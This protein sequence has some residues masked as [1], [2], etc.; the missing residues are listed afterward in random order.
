[1]SKTKIPVLFERRGA[2]GICPST[3][4]WRA[5]IALAMKGVE[6]Q[7]RP[8][9]FV[10]AD[11]FAAEVG[12]RQVPVLVDGGKTIVGSDRI[13]MHLDQTRVGPAVGPVDDSGPGTKVLESDLGSRILPL[14]ARDMLPHLAPEDRDYYRA[15]R[16]ERLGISFE[17]LEGKRTAGELDLA[18]AIGRLEGSL[19]ELPFFA[20]EAPGWSDVVAFC[21]LFWI[22]HVSPRSVP[23]L[24][25]TLRAWYEGR[26]DAWRS[27][28]L[29]PAE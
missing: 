3:V 5:R 4:C 23:E 24:P 2:N 1:M 14:V 26:R 11:D 9:R 25:Y 29:E 16:E 12:T 6:H 19:G 8:M 7:R 22:D 27:I 18:F 15:S 17:A 13:A 28:C 10:D 20:G 21:F